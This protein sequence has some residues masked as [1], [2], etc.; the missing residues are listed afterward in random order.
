MHKNTCGDYDLAPICGNGFRDNCLRS[1]LRSVQ[2]THL[3]WERKRLISQYGS[4]SVYY[5]DT[6]K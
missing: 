5:G 6:D 3:Y 2:L 1:P 4:K